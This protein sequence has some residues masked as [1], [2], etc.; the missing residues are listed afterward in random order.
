MHGAW[1]YVGVAEGV[2][3]RGGVALLGAWLCERGGARLRGVGGR[4]QCG[5]PGSGC[6]FGSGFVRR[7]PPGQPLVH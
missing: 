6:R 4:V 5:S 1:L 2:A 7:R 3:L